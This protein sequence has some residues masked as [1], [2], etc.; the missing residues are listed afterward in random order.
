MTGPT[1][2]DDVGRATVSKDYGAFATH[3]PAARQFMR[4]L[5][6]RYDRLL[7]LRRSS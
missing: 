7:S 6:S 5:P 1:L 2:A 3:T 4:D